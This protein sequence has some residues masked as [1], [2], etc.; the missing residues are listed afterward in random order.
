MIINNTEPELYASRMAPNPITFY[1]L[2]IDLVENPYGGV[3][4]YTDGL[5]WM[6]IQGGGSGPGGPESDP[7]WTSE[8]ANYPTTTTVNNKIAAAVAGLVTTAELA[9]YATNASVDSKIAAATSDVVTYQVP[10]R[11]NYVNSNTFTLPKTIE[12]IAEV[13]LYKQDDSYSFLQD[14]EYTYSGQNI[15]IN[16]AMSSGMAIKVFY[17]AK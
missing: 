12:D 17:F 15:T 5:R 4:K 13:R 8:K 2:W 1:G 6:P 10:V 11:F 7:I 16:V 9:N 3:I 14:N